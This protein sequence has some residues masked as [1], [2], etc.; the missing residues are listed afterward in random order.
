MRQG[1]VICY[2]RHEECAWGTNEL[3]A[4]FYIID[5]YHLLLYGASSS[6]TL[7]RGR[8]CGRNLG[9]ALGTKFLLSKSGGRAMNLVRHDAWTFE[10]WT[11]KREARYP[12]THFFLAHR[13]Q[14]R[15]RAT[16]TTAW[17]PGSR[18]CYKKCQLKGKAITEACSDMTWQVVYEFQPLQSWHVFRTWRNGFRVEGRFPQ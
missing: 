15:S 6:K 1:I 12:T 16:H 8:S 14:M 4:D 7:K 11:I 3:W 5:G 9:T 10:L 17:Y 18:H 2:R 13:S